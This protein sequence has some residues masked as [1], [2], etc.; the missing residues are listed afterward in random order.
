MSSSWDKFEEQLKT[1]M[2]KAYSETVIEHSMNPRNMGEM[3]GAD[4]FAR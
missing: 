4:G 1:K 3:E 2:L